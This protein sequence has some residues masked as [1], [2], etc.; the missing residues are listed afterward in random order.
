MLKKSV[1]GIDQITP[2]MTQNLQH[3][4]V[5]HFTSLFNHT[6]FTI[7]YP[8]KWK[9]AFVIPLLKPLKDSTQPTS[10]RPIFLLS[11]LDKIFEKI[12]NKCGCRR[13]RWTFMAVADLNAQQIYEA[14]CILLYGECVPTHVMDLPYTCN[15]LQHIGLRGTLPLV[16]RNFLADRTFK[17]RVANEVS[18][19]KI[20]QNGI[21]QGSLLSGTLPKSNKRHN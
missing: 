19:T 16:L 6:L 11:S 9:V 18:E 15:M 7:V 2:N 3:N 13:K 12:I 14:F 17:V 1:L 5:A 20:Q 21:P 8:F 10:Y 4:A